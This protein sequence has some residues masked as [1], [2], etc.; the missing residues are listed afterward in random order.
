V[1]P[2]LAQRTPGTGDI[3][4]CSLLSAEDAEKVVGETLK[5]QE[6][7]AENKCLYVGEVE[8]VLVTVFEATDEA[9]AVRNIENWR[10]ISRAEKQVVEPV[11]ALADEAFIT[12]RGEYDVKSWQIHARW[13][14]RH[15]AINLRTDVP[16]PREQLK[17]LI[18]TALARL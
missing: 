16:D 17:T 9:D 8:Q 4:P 15:I 1:P 10:D 2:D 11:S 5:P 3:D 14:H 18:S 7:E 12:V 6:T 13:Q